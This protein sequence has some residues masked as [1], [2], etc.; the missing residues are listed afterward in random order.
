MSACGTLDS[1]ASCGP[2]PIRGGFVQ[3]FGVGAVARGHVKAVVMW[4]VA[5]N[6]RCTGHLSAIASRRAR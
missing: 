4:D 2:E 1:G 5:S 3:S 6:V